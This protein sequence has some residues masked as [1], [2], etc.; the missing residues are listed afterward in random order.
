MILSCRSCLLFFFFLQAEDGIRDIGVT[1]VR[2]CALPITTL[3]HPFLTVDGWRKLGELSIGDHIAVPRRMPVFGD[4]P[5]GEHRVKLLAYM[6]GDGN[7]TGGV[8]RFTNASAVV[9]DDFAR[10]IAAFGG[11]S[12]R[13]EDSGG[14]RTA[15]L[16]VSADWNVMHREREEFARTLRRAVEGSPRPAS[17]IAWQA[18]VSPA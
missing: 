12:L 8:P 10:A 16:C 15:T 3:S 5:I 11:L 6:L 4:E 18:R 9:R 14:T 17:W 13:E 7:M 2:T 1:G